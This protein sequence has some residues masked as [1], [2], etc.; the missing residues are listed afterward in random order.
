M[1]DSGEEE[2]KLRAKRLLFL[3]MIEGIAA[4]ALKCVY[5]MSLKIPLV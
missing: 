5:A 3:K 4:N 2:N 1:R